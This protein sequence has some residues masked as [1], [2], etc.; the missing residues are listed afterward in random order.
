MN[1]ELFML[2]KWTQDSFSKKNCCPEC[3][4][5]LC[6]QGLGTDEACLI[7]IICTR[8]SNQMKEIVKMYQQ[9]KATSSHSYTVIFKETNRRKTYSKVFKYVAVETRR[10]L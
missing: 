4:I 8:S 9:R 1:G 7:E 3:F 5:C 10:L 6:H 2:V